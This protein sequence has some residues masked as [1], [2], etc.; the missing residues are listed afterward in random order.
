MN[1]ETTKHFKSRCKERLGISKKSASGYFAKA[2]RYGIR[3]CEF[4][5]NELLR[6]YLNKVVLNCGEKG[7]ECICYHHHIIIYKPRDDGIGFVVITVL[8]IPKQYLNF[9]DKE[10]EERRK[11]TWKNKM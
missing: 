9:V 8:N 2:Y 6:D 4:K 3:S 10:F 7:M 11:Y 1:L 5:N